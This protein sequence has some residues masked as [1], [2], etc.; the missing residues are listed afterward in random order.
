MIHVSKWTKITIPFGVTE[1]IRD[2]C[3]EN[4]GPKFE[5][6][7]LSGNAHYYIFFIEDPEKATLFALKWK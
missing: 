2:W 1:K 3:E 6:W 5:T 7:Y 4:I